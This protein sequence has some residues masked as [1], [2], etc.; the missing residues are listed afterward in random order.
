MTLRDY[1]DKIKS[2]LYRCFDEEV[3]ESKPD[4]NHR[5]LEEALELVQAN[6]IS[7][8]ECHQILNYV[9]ARPKG[10]L[11]QEV[12]GVITTLAALCASYKVDLED[13]ALTE[14]DRIEANVER[15]REKQRGKPKFYE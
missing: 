15:I 12:G 11:T 5:F 8:E 10:E 6:G 3:C 9:Y 13:C 2:W 1:Q 7:H 4:R 14:L